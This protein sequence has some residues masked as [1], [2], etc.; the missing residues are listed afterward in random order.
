LN[1]RTAAR[2]AARRTLYGRWPRAGRLG[3]GYTVL[4]PLPG[5]LPVFLELAMAGCAAQDPAGRVET[6]VVA[7][8][9]TPAFVAAFERL[10]RRFDVGP[11][12]LIPI[13]RP[14]RA[15]QRLTGEP[16]LNHYLQL[17]HGIGAA[18]T[19]FAVL[20]DAD[21][22]L[23]DPRFMAARYERC[24]DE[25]LDYLGVEPVF[26]DWYDRHG[27]GPVLATWEL[28]FDVGSLRRFP[29]WQVH[30]HRGV[31]GGVEHDFDTMDYPQ[32]HT[33]VDKRV[34]WEAP[35]GFVHFRWSTTVYRYFQQA[36]GRPFEDQ[37][38]R[39]LLIRLL[40]DAFAG[41]DPHPNGELPAVGELA[42]GIGDE[43]ARVTYQGAEREERYADFRRMIGQVMEGDLIEP[44]RAE[45]MDRAL[46]P[47]DRA[48]AGG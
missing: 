37:R 6:L 10:R 16:Y 18:R 3:D 45:T 15:L 4:M 30:S 31:I 42:R 24:R 19:R 48:F 36:A 1:L 11:A 25:D 33:P 28:M 23:N 39:L 17:Y 27:H 43:T 47:F 2:R 34:L 41:D 46:R 35:D 12:R 32:V 29:A 22:F 38:F 8:Q 14:G 7:D 40:T 20:W 21:L 26:D 9:R 44:A 5:D 13:G